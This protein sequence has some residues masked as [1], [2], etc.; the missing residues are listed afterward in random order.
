[1]IL[2]ADLQ[3]IRKQAVCAD[4]VG[5]AFL[6]NEIR[7]RGKRRKCFYCHGTD[8]AYSIDGIF[9]GGRARL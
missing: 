2:E 5:E 1:M 6:K 4:C 7:T 3:K 9:V 8:R